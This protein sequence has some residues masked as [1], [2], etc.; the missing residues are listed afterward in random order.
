MHKGVEPATAFKIMEIVRKGNATKLLTQEHIDTMK[1]NGVEQW[2]IDSCMKIKYMFPKAHAAA[3]VS[4]ALRLGWYKIYYPL[5]YYAAFMTVRGDDIDAATVL[6]GRQAVKD[7]MADIKRRGKE[8]L[9]KEQNMYPSLQVV[10]EMMA[11]GVEF[12][13]IDIYKSDATVYKIEDGKIRMPFGALSGVGENAA[14]SL[15]K[16]REGVD[17]F[18]SIDDFAQR[19]GAGSSMI[20][21]LKQVGAFGSLPE[22]RQISLFEM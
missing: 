18:V 3:Y 7:L 12:L 22:T 13:P 10:N 1:E 9:P 16:A 17:E 11:R 14:I 4:A 8:A 20:E 2:Y 15:A 19:A 5:E 21:L 6:K